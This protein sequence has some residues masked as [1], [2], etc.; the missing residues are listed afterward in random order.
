[1]RGFKGKGFLRGKRRPAVRLPDHE[2]VMRR[3]V[4]GGLSVIAIV[5]HFLIEILNLNDTSCSEIF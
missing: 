4:D 2:S 1:M 3:H 5:A